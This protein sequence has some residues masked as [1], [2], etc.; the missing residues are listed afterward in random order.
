MSTRRRGSSTA[1]HEAAT[2]H[3]P[4]GEAAEKVPIARA[5]IAAGA[6]VDAKDRDGATP[7]LL[8]AKRYDNPLKLVDL[9][10]EAGARV[11]AKDSTGA[12]PLSCACAMSQL[13]IAIRLLDAGARSHSRDASGMTPLLHAARNGYCDLGYVLLAHGVKPPERRRARELAKKSNRG[14]FV[15][16]L[17]GEQLA[18][19]KLPQIVRAQLEK[20]NAQFAKQRY[21]AAVAAYARVPSSFQGRV[22]EG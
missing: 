20:A 19:S 14:E 22:A 1:L 18:A 17:D 16:V 9:L 15:R 8:A 13:D 3:K 4:P 10:L 6:A 12:T 21:A 7:L 5:L 2:R 11:N